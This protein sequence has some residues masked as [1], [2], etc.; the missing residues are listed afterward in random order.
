M[1]VTAPALPRGPS[2]ETCRSCGGRGQVR[3][4]QG[5][6]TMVRTCPSVRRERPDGCPTRAPPAAAPG[7]SRRSASSRSRSRQGSRT[8][9]GCGWSARARPALRGGPAGDLYVVVRVEPHELF[10]R[11]GAA[12]PSRAGDL[13]FRGGAGSRARGAHAGR[14]RDSQG[15]CGRAAGRHRGAERAR[16]AASA[17]VRQGRP[18]R[19]PEGGGAPQADGQAA[20]TAAVL[21][22]RARTSTR[23]SFA[24]CVTSSRVAVEHPVPHGHLPLARE[25][26]GAAGQR[27]GAV[28]GPRMPG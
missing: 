20:R 19:A 18:G 27:A 21:W 13:R 7:G 15:A 10:V 24:R 9:P 23:A 17:A 28:A 26:R 2:R 11:E 3:V 1:R 4:S 12:P 22:S 5:F 25:R 16:A 8:A 6:F 14:D